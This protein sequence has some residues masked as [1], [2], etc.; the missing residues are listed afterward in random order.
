MKCQNRVCVLCMLIFCFISISSLEAQMR[1]PRLA[2][3]TLDN[4]TADANSTIG[5]AVTDILFTELGKKGL[6]QLV[7]RA[8]SEDIEKETGGEG[9]ILGAEFILLGK[10]SNFSFNETSFQDNVLTA[11]GMVRQTRYRQNAIVRVDFRIVSTA[12]GVAVV[13]ESGAASKNNISATAEMATYASLRQTGIFSGEAQ[14]SLIGRTT[15][16]AID[17]VV[18]K[19]SDLSRVLKTNMPEEN[20][21]NDSLR[22]ISGHVSGLVNGAVFV[23]MGTPDH[24]IKKGDHLK[25]FDEIITKNSQGKVLF[26]EEQEVATLDVLAV[27]GQNVKTQL[28]D[29]FTKDKR[30]PREGDKVRIDDGKMKGRNQPPI[31][32]DRPVRSNDQ[33]LENT[34]EVQRLVKEG[35]RYIED[36]YFAQA[37]ECYQKALTL[38]PNSPDIMDKLVGVLLGLREMADAED[39]MEHLFAL[40]G[41]ISVS[42]IIH[43][44][45]T[46]Y[47]FGE[48]IIARSGISYI[49]Q[50]GDHEFDARPEEV[51]S[52]EEGYLG[53]LPDMIIRFRDSK[54]KLKKYD[55]LLPGY[56]TFREKAFG[57]VS[58]QFSGNAQAI[59]DTAKVHRMLIRLAKEKVL[60]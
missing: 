13:T 43:N 31:T 9:R 57:N 8:A 33:S 7:D 53:A 5:N 46:G 55:L 2:I 18:R 49:P 38:Q 52:L 17:D 22:S 29:T 32:A 60:R 48:L 51:E 44:H 10:V 15:I 37:K 35:D 24:G 50:K 40:K 20:V 27:N 26:T 58:D 36:K 25:V 23:D 16:A 11:R 14:N 59:S 41:K 39:L 45:S 12:T 42:G 34:D 1:K 21:G 56:L 28:I 19:I 4:P 47:C 6:F 54:G 30:N 3:K